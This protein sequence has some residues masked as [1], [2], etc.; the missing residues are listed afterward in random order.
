MVK[1]YVNGN[2]EKVL[3]S[4]KRWIDDKEYGEK[5]IGKDFNT[6]TGEEGG[7]IEM[8]EAEER[9]VRREK[10]KDKKVKRPENK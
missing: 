5:T 3:G 2:L 1:V 7:S 9:G 10:K 4:L 8:E 6:R